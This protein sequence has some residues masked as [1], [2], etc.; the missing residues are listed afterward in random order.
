MPKWVDFHQGP[1]NTGASRLPPLPPPSASVF[2]SWCCALVT[3]PSTGSAFV[4]SHST[5]V[6]SG[7]SQLPQAPTS[8]SL[9]PQSPLPSHTHC[10]SYV[11]H[12]MNQDGHCSLRLETSKLLKRFKKRITWSD[13]CFRKVS[14]SGRKH[15]CHIIGTYYAVGTSS[16][17][18]KKKS[19]FSLP[20]LWD[21]SFLEWVTKHVAAES[22]HQQ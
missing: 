8:P 7:A 9:P 11:G 2:P 4:C 3:T 10:F 14:H 12:S 22:C 20:F 15:Y 17:V 1:G 13:L 6:F 5:C 21:E 16:S 19:V 18:Q